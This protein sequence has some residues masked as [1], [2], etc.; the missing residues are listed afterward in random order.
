MIK[1]ANRLRLTSCTLSYYNYS[2]VCKQLTLRKLVYRYDLPALAIMPV[3][4]VLNVTHVSSFFKCISQNV[5]TIYI[6]QRVQVYLL[7][8]CLI[9]VSFSKLRM[10]VQEC[11]M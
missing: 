3:I 9:F 11:F 2:A 7:Y 4:F 8:A 1:I 5:I 6:L 10:N